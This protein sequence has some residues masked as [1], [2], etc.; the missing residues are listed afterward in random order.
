MFKALDISSD[1]EKLYSVEEEQKTEEN[2]KKNRKNIMQ[3]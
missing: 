2:G 3:V 1:T